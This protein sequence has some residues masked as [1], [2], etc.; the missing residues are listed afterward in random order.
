MLKTSLNQIVD[1]SAVGENFNPINL[2]DLLI[3]AAKEKD[4]SPAIEDREKVLMINIDNQKDF[5]EKGS[6]GV[7]GSHQDVKNQIQFIYNNLNKITRIVN[8]LDTH[9][10]Q[11]IFFPCF[12]VDK[13][14]NHPDP[15]TVITWKDIVDGVWK[16]VVDPEK[17]HSYIENLEKLGK[18]PLMIWTYHCI[19]GTD[20]CSLENQFANMVYF[21]SVIRK[22]ASVRLV[23][24]QDPFSEMYGIFKPEYDPKNTINTKA[25]DLIEEYDK[26]IIAGQAKSHCV[27][28]SIQQIADYYENRPDITSKI[29]ILEDCMSSIPN[30]EK[31]TEELFENYKNQYKM[32]IIKSTDLIL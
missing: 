27:A 30:F 4:V 14:G 8:S 29:Y 16:S 6:L 15:F 7:P 28:T 26:I 21:H 25:L 23:K 11:Q 20:G 24:G 22:V 12:W 5:M 9:I 31:V 18:S 17:S 19:Q 10:P 1:L 13:Y 32:N 3:Q 2:N